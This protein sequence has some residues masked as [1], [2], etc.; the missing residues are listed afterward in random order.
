MSLFTVLRRPGVG[1]LG[2]AGLLS[3]TGDWMIF[4][5]L[6]LFVLQLS[7]SP[8]L[9]ATVFALELVPTVVASPFAGV[10]IDRLEPWRLMTA[11]A[12]LQAIAL[13]PLLTVQT[14][15]E[16]WVFYA[17]VVV[18][19]ILGTV[20]E[21]CRTV[22]A[23]ALV[24]PGELGALN[25]G[26]GLLSALAR[27][28]GGPLGGLALGLSGID[29]VLIA[30]AATF[31]VAATLFGLRR[32]NRTAVRVATGV[33]G[34]RLWHDWAE[35]LTVIARSPVLRRTMAVVACMALAQGAFLVLFV[36]FVVRDLG[37]SEGD[38][39]V[40]RGVQAIGALAG[41]L[42][43]GPVLR[44]LSAAQLAAVSL[45][46]FGILSLVT[47]NAPALT[48]AFGLYVGLF[49]AVGVPGIASMTGLLTLVQAAVAD[50][51]R[52]R[53]VS[54][55]FAVYGGVQAA[56]MLIAGLVGTGAGLT[57]ALQIQGALYLAAAVLAWRVS[58]LTS[59][60]ASPAAPPPP[61]DRPA[62][63]PAGRPR[64]GTAS[65]PRTPS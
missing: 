35:G 9:T 21:P 15:E 43:L 29:A 39:G 60:A 19:S 48:T 8:L 1:R 34:V 33:R 11:V 13:L 38:V 45:A 30:D 64:A 42:L 58:R 63:S 41:G 28:V 53:V 22:T 56:G 65:R 44:R 32:S 3:E 25:Q 36:L 18:E 12:L 17:V 52:G 16:L 55:L 31:L 14:A 26:L 54:S 46:A 6:P 5:A 2:L 57:V 49:I 4:I 27:L 61:A 40:L 24:P 7:G 59:A 20:I 23:A 47:W 10:L 51:A 37:G 62:P 50:Q